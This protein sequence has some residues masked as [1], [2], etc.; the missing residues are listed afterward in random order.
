MPT[1]PGQLV[2]YPVLNLRELGL[3]ARAYVE[4]LEDSIIKFLGEAGAG[5]HA[6]REKHVS[7]ASGNGA[8]AGPCPP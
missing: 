5:T 2:A 7:S 6:C 3:G 4:G 8:L 1:G